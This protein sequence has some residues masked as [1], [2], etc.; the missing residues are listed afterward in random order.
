MDWLRSEVTASSIGDI[1]I[2]VRGRNA[3]AQPERE[4]EALAPSQSAGKLRQSLGNGAQK[5][6]NIHAISLEFTMDHPPEAS[7]YRSEAVISSTVP[8]APRANLSSAV[9]SGKA[10]RSRQ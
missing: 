6:G 1:V 3:S 10:R 5:T 4:L 7:I 9:S 2:A 8:L